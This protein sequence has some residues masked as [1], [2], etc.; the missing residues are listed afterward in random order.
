M[1]TLEELEQRARAALAGH[2]RRLRASDDEPA[3]QQLARVG[4]DEVSRIL[5]DLIAHLRATGD[6]TE[7]ALRERLR[8]AL[9]RAEKAEAEV[10]SLRAFLSKV[11]ASYL[12][13]P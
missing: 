4:E 3:D 2:A 9:E 8:M 5:V 13:R 1:T 10:E 11:P 6:S 12:E 7:A